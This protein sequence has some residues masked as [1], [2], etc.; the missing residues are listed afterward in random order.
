MQLAFFTAVVVG[1]GTAAAGMVEGLGAVGF[2][3]PLLTILGFYGF[4]QLQGFVDRSDTRQQFADS[5]Y[6]L[7]FLLTMVAMLAGFLPAGLLGQEIT[8]QGILRHFSMA[9]GATAL[10][11]VCRILV[12]QGGRSLGEITAEVE[13]TLTQY[14]RQVS[15]EAQSIASELAAVRAQV[16]LQR[17]QVTSLVTVDL[18]NSVQEAFE[19]IVQSAKA[20]SGNLSSQTEQIVS[21]AQRLQIAL[22]QSAE[23]VA[24]INEVRDEAKQAAEV[25]ATNVAGALKKF[26]LQIL[27][28]RKSLAEAVSSSTLEVQKMGSAFEQTA[29]LAPTLTPVLGTITAN[30]G[31][32]SEQMDE[33]RRQSEALAERFNKGIG[34]D[35]R[36]LAGLEEAQNRIVASIDEAGKTARSAI[37]Q[38][39]EFNRKSL[40][41]GMESVTATMRA[42]A[43]RFQNELTEATQRLSGILSDFAARIEEV[44]GEAHR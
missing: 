3:G 11:L 25:A 14:A 8:S 39:S 5:C 7:G 18:R 32:V 40:A 15:N 17:E 4:G 22:S 26:E 23:Q 28:L 9:L 13:A 30:V 27:E 19:P 2:A 31:S 6:F 24:T 20:I 41:D 35:G 43:E 42:D 12:L 34:E 33:V 21:S 10:G 29:V 1:V 16:E 38:Q 44:R 37:E 36:L